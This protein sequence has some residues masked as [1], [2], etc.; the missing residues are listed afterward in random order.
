MTKSGNT[1]SA[2]PSWRTGVITDGDVTYEQDGPDY[3]NIYDV[4]GAIQ[5]GWD[6]KL[7]KAS[8]YVGTPGVDMSKIFDHCEKMR[9]RYDRAMIA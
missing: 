6:M 8:Q 5:S 9:S 3:D 2:E 4:R 7:A 1:G